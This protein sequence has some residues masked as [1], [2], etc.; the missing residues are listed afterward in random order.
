MRKRLEFYV[1]KE[2]RA[3]NG[4]AEVTFRSKRAEAAEVDLNSEPL[5]VWVVF[6]PDGAQLADCYLR[7]HA[8]LV[9]AALNGKAG[10]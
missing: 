7:A 1:R 5:P 10:R 3:V 9:C 6:R 2:W 8:M 4:D